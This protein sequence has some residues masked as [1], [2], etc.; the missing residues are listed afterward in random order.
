MSHIG[1]AL[2]LS[3]FGG[4]GWGEEAFSLAALHRRTGWTQIMRKLENQTYLPP[5]GN[6]LG[7]KPAR[8]PPWENKCT[9]GRDM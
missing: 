7:K 9:H 4:E 6:Q 5:P 1:E 8:K 3:S 2:P